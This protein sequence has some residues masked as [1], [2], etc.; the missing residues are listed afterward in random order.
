M[1]KSE[2]I[3]LLIFQEISQEICSTIQN[4]YC[5]R[6]KHIIR[7]RGYTGSQVN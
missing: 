3:A 1:E 4:Q 6:V 7:N 5:D 2:K